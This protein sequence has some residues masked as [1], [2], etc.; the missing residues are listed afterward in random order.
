MEAA[1][2]AVAS[3][4]SQTNLDY[5]V[6]ALAAVLGSR[7]AEIPAI[8]NLIIRGPTAS[9]P[10]EVRLTVGSCIMVGIVRAKLLIVILVA[11]TYIHIWLLTISCKPTWCDACLLVMP[12]SA[13]PHRSTHDGKFTRCNQQK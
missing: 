13:F 3:A 4:V 6:V 9:G 5:S 2:P 11:V 10:A 8:H 12:M 7:H 1:V